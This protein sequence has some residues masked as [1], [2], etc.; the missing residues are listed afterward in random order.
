MVGCRV[1]GTDGEISSVSHGN[2][3]S[4]FDHKLVR[5]ARSRST[6]TAGILVQLRALSVRGAAAVLSLEFGYVVGVILVGNCFFILA[7]FDIEPF[8]CGAGQRFEGLLVVG[9][10]F[11]PSITDKLCDI[12]KREILCPN[13]FSDLI[14]EDHVGRQWPVWCSFV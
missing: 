3:G 8:L 4:C 1:D 5:P 7:K 10:Q 13:F 9:G 2:S 14:G 12:C 6:S 11:L